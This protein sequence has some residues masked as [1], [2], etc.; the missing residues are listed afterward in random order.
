MAHDPDG[1]Q[2]G[3]AISTLGDY[4]VQAW[5]ALP[6]VLSALQDPDFSV[7]DT[8]TNALQQIAPQFLSNGRESLELG[9]LWLLL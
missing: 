4:G 6:T 8:A 7:R 1:I 5:P 9:L 3:W 2:R